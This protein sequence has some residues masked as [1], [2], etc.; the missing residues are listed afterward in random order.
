MAA[1]ARCTLA[2]WI[3]GSTYD[4]AKPFYNIDTLLAPAEQVSDGT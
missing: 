1:C 4:E 3:A 2:Y